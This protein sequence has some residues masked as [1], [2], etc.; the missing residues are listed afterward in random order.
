M[1]SVNAEAMKIVRKI[2]GAPEALGVA[3]SRLANGSKTGRTF[4]AGRVDEEGLARS[5]F[6]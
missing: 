2:L 5:F 1:L 4:S 3:I 6:A